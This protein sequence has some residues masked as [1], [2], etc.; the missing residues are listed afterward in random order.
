MLFSV[1]EM[2]SLRK[3]RHGMGINPCIAGILQS[4]AYVGGME[5]K[6]EQI[7]GHEHYFDLCF[8]ALIL[9]N[10][11]LRVADKINSEHVGRLHSIQ[12]PRY[13]HS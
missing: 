10:N 4:T 11:S 2:G 12:K 6:N 5:K 1:P 9:C 7:M 3:G 8:V 13:F